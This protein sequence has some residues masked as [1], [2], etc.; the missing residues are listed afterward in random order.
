M[1]GRW[2]GRD[3]I[4]ETNHNNLFIYAGSSPSVYSDTFGLAWNS[5]KGKEAL[6]LA[7][8]MRHTKETLPNEH[9]CCNMIRQVADGDC[10]TFAAGVIE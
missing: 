4:N 1:E 7:V 6:S 3:L 10:I 8:K 2:I 5:D 9:P